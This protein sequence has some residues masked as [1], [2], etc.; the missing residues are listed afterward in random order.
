[1]S[2]LSNEDFKATIHKTKQQVITNTPETNEKTESQ[3]RN[4]R[5]KEQRSGN[6]R[7]KKYNS[8]N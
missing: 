3:Q 5:Y 2:E 7:M 6:F 4:K 8:Q 1:M